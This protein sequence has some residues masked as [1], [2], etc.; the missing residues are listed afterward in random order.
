[1]TKAT[2]LFV[3]FPRSLGKGK[4]DYLSP[5]LPLE[6]AEDTRKTIGLGGGVH[7]QSASS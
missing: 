4:R 5:C 1:M 3:S 7:S 6:A 2:L